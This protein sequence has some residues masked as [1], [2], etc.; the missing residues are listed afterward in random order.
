MANLYY[1]QS[2]NCQGTPRAVLSSN[3]A[4]C[5]LNGLPAQYVGQQFPATSQEPGPDFALLRIFEEEMNEEWRAGFYRFEDDLT[6]MEE[7]VQACIAELA[8]VGG[9]ESGELVGHCGC[10]PRGV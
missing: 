7:A 2:V 8:T 4:R 9:K 10:R 6:Q 3:E 1:S 5:L